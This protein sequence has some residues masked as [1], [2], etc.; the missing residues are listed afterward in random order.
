MVYSAHYLSIYTAEEG[1]IKGSDAV[2]R[3]VIPDLNYTT[4]LKTTNLSNLDSVQVSFVLVT[5]HFTIDEGDIL[6]GRV[7]TDKFHDDG[8][9]MVSDDSV[10]VRRSEYG[11]V[12]RIYQNTDNEGYKYCKVRL[13]KIK[14][15]DV[16]DK[17]AVTGKKGLV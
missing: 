6:I 5:T 9:P 14:I 3:F 4:G 8:T 13:R 7:V 10:Y 11:I 1:A 17:F 2:E 12:D 15:P 16:G